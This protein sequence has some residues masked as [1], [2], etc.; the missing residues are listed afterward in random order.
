VCLAVPK[1]VHTFLDLPYLFMI[2]YVRF[3]EDF[4]HVTCG[5]RDLCF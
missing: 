3:H 4:I 2:C 5:P 1:D